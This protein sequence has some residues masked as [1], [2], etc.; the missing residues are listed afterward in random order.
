MAK[1]TPCIS[2][3][4][5]FPML[6][7]MTSTV[8]I[9]PWAKIAPLVKKS[10]IF[11]PRAL[12][13]CWRDS[14]PRKF[15]CR[16]PNA[17]AGQRP[18][19]R[20]LPC[21]LPPP[22]IFHH[23]FLRCRSG[24]DGSS[25][26]YGFWWRNP[27][28]KPGSSDAPCARSMKNGALIGGSG[29]GPDELAAEG[30]DDQEHWML[31]AGE[32]WHGFG[33]LAEGFNMLDPIKATIITPAW[34]WTVTFRT[35]V[36]RPAFSPNTWRNMASSLKMWPVQLL[37]HV[38]HRH[39]QRSLEHLVTELQQFKDCYDGNSKSADACRSLPPNT[40]L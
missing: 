14:K 31:K 21:T 24:H 36:S 5:G 16:T 32:R 26:R 19:Q 9:T 18:V 4:P 3:K 30:M 35:G 28:V 20:S 12:T 38:Y 27:S 11:P 25:G 15:W 22:A 33:D 29:M 10:L 17:Q 37:H 39:H 6:R 2:M 8:T 7:S 23:C 1:L 34:M 13:N 40:P